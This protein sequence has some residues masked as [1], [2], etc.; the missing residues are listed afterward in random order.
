M[1]KLLVRVITSIAVAAIILLALGG[2]A[3]PVQAGGGAYVFPISPYGAAESISPTFVWYT[4]P[5]AV[6][7]NVVIYNSKWKLVL[8]QPVYSYNCG[9]TYCRYTT[10][11]KLA[12][13]AGYYWDVDAWMANG[14]EVFSANWVDFTVSLPFSSSFSNTTGWKPVAGTWAAHAGDYNGSQSINPTGYLAS[15]YY[16][17]GQYDTYTYEARIKNGACADCANMVVFNGSPAH[18]DGIGDWTN[19]YFFAYSNE[20]DFIIVDEYNGAWTHIVS[21]TPETSL[22]DP[23]SWNILTVTYN[24]TTGFTQFFINHVEVAEET[25]TDH[26]YGYVGLA[27]YGLASTDTISVDYANLMAG[28]PLHQVSSGVTR[29]ANFVQFTGKPVQAG[30][31]PFSR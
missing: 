21:W 12:V 27:E 30:N 26:S 9:A 17:K 10:S 19:A 1:N 8:N 22:I 5:G 20:G 23:Y 15:A 16:Y 28:A 2:V 7:Y 18:L 3:A 13:G 31:D 29:A 25:L 24:A 14:D 6:Q 11:K 4:Y